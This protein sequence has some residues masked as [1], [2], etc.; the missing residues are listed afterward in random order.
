[1][2]SLIKIFRVLGFTSAVPLY[3]LLEVISVVNLRYVVACCCDA[4][5]GSSILNITHLL[6]FTVVPCVCVGRVCEIEEKGDLVVF[7]IYEMEY[8]IRAAKRQFSPQLNQ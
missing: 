5:I 3:M 4:L 2:G 7:T 8:G 6:F 1:M